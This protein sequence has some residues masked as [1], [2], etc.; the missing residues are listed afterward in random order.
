MDLDLYIAGVCL[1]ILVL[2]LLGLNLMSME[3]SSNAF[4]VWR[5][6][7]LSF[8]LE[9]ICTVRRAK[10]NTRKKNVDISAPFTM[11]FG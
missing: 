8:R 9:Q 10:F 11:I 4:D 2:S 7:R 1:K 6:D 5:Y 3:R